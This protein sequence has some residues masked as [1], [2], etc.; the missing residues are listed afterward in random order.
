MSYGRSKL[1]NVLFSSELS[2]RLAGSGVQVN[3]LH[4]G[5]IKTNLA[6]HV[7]KGG[8]QWVSDT[9]MPQLLMTPQQ[10]AVTSMYLATSADILD[11]GINGLYYHPQA[12]LTQPSVYCTKENQKKLWA[13]SE[14]LTET[15]MSG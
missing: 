7:D 14:N 1:A 15:F 12:R 8:S 9:L 4:P 6:R 3:A 11:R 10:G 13:L 5:G 2:E